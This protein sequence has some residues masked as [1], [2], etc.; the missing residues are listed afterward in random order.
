MIATP[1]TPAVFDE[2]APV[3]DDARNPFCA[4]EARLLRQLLPSLR[5]KT[6]LDAGCGTGRHFPLLSKLQ[7][8]WIYA[9]DYSAQMLELAK[10]RLPSN[11][12]L[13]RADCTAIPLPARSIDVVLCSLVVGYVSDLAAFC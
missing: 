10:Q 1:A 13:H 8:A 6:I 12:T 5:G 2:W 11:A 9:V 3:Y 7:T 4:L